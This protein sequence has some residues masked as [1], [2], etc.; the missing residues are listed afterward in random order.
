LISLLSVSKEF[1]AG[2]A[3]CRALADVSL[4][5]ALG[6]A[7]ALTGPSGSG[8]T[9]LLSLVGCL[10]R[11]TSGRILLE[12]REISGL[13]EPHL[14]RLRRERFGFLFQQS[15]LIPGLTALENVMLP[16]YPAGEPRGV[17]A[18]R[19]RSLLAE[20]GVGEKAPTRAN[21]LSGGEQQRVALARA[22]VNRPDVLL[23]DEPTAHLDEGDT[24]RLLELLSS[25]R[26]RGLTLVVAT[27][28]PAVFASPIFSRRVELRDGRVAR[29]EGRL[30]P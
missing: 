20:L 30:A 29:V 15:C 16:A 26:G 24:D 28:D 9:T 10:A 22:L 3:R 12:G 11:S 5:I 27:H 7:T 14:S 21:R 1:G 23:A 25:L 17:L 13:P 8:K 19:A 6:E 4:D 18:E 2:D